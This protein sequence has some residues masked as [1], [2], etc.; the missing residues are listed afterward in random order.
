MKQCT[1]NKP[2]KNN[3]MKLTQEQKEANKLARQE[4][5]QQEKKEAKILAEKNQKPVDYINFSIEWSKQGNPTCEAVIRYTDGA[6]DR[7]TA[8][9]GGGGYCKES[10]VIA[11]IFNA[12]M[13]YKLYELEVGKLFN[14]PYGINSYN[15][16][17][18]FAGGVG[19]S[20]YY[21][22]SKFIGGEFQ[23]LASGKAYDAYKLTIKN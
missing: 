1:D 12:T 10:T 2:I 11:E 23:K 13:K 7:I 17:H 8:R 3:I 19:A 9:A 21:D 6:S 22:I 16:S 14:L 4:K 18:C 5:R 20:C 15:N